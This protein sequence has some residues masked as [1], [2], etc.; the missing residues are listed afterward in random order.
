MKI[1]TR[2]KLI[3]KIKAIKKKATKV[4]IKKK[5]KIIRTINQLI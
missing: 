4:I 5:N 3:S 2:I 1:V